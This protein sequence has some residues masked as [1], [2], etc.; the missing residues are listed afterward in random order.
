MKISDFTVEE[1]FSRSNLIN[2]LIGLYGYKSYLEIGVDIGANFEK[3][4][5][6][7]KVGVDP[8]NKYEKLTHNITSDEFFAQNEEKFDIVF[9]D[10][11]HLSDQVIKDIQ[12]S[13]DVLNP[14]GTI[15]M[16]DCL[17]NS[18]FAQSRERLG[19][20]WNGD[21]WKAFAHYRKNP[22]LIMFTVNTD[23]GL[24]FI[25]RGKQDTFDTPEELDYSFFVKNAN[26][27]MNVASV[28]TSLDAINKLHASGF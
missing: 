9:I 23:Q 7:Y 24:G 16:H 11:L 3:V 22:D 15:I 10:G 21:V 20:H 4:N 26:E 5:C 17:P 6:A 19:D 25:K 12:N 1:Y 27:M 14:L 28:S 2:Y 13:L 8:S 18:E